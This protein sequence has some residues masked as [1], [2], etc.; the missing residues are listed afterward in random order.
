[1]KSPSGSSS[2]TECEEE[3]DMTLGDLERRV[4]LAGGGGGGRGGGGGGGGG[5]EGT[6]G[7]EIAVRNGEEKRRG[8]RKTERMRVSE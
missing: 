3:T 4:G 8:R 7:N 2:M 5:G 6:C 1:M